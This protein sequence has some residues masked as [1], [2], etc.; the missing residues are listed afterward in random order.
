MK[1]SATAAL[2]LA[3]ALGLAGAAE[4]QSWATGGPTPSDWRNAVPGP[5]G[6][7]N[8]GMA[9]PYTG[10]PYATEGYGSSMPPMAD[11]P[12]TNADNPQAPPGAGG[13]ATG[14]PYLPRW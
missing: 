8:R 6:P 13:F 1:H 14:L 12:L 2:A 3:F 4:A 9:L 11:Q 5:L 10:A 7:T